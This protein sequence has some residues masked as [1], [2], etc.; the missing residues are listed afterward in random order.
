MEGGIA[1]GTHG[2]IGASD[3]FSKDLKRMLTDL[4][5]QIGSL[6]SDGNGNL[7]STI[8][9]HVQQGNNILKT[10][11]NMSNYVVNA[12]TGMVAPIKEI[13]AKAIHELIEAF[14]TTLGNLIPLGVVTTVITL[15]KN[16]IQNIFCKT[17]SWLVECYWGYIR[18][19]RWV[20]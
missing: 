19:Y 11:G 12:V 6:G 14:V 1:D 9:G 17:C 20:Y 10:I 5:V 15:I 16:I 13:L 18:K 7:V 2:P 8:T 4:G 3:S